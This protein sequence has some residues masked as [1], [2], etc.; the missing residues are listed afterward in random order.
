MAKLYIQ[1]Q[2][3]KDKAGFDEYYLNTHM[4]LA[5]NVPNIKASSIDRVIQS[6]NTTLNL[7]MIVV[8]EFADLPTLQSAMATPEWKAVMEDAKNLEKFLNEPPIIMITQ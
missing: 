6:Q 2:Q 8:I 7:Y 5:K 4:P 1:Y 3:P